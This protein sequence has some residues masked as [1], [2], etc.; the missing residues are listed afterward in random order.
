ML[1]ITLE[2]PQFAWKCGEIQL[3]AYISKESIYS[4]V[5]TAA[6]DI[7]I[8]YDNVQLANLLTATEKNKAVVRIGI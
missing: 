3:T 2:F 1:F 7:N 8:Y 4:K 5:Y 6:A